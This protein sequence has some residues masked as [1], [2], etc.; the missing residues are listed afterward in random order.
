MRVRSRRRTDGS[1]P[2]DAAMH[3]RFDESELRAKSMEDARHAHGR[4]GCCLGF[5]N[6]WRTG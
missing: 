4:V 2:V 6:D 1:A 5:R 3:D